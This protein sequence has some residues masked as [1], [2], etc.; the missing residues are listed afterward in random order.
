MFLAY[1]RIAVISLE[2]VIYRKREKFPSENPE[3]GHD[4]QFTF[5]V[6][7][8]QHVIISRVRIFCQVLMKF[9]HI[10]DLS[11]NRSREVVPMTK[12][13]SVN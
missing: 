13:H 1:S 4:I 9:S 3:V 12:H 2:N 11:A 10:K 7:F 8:T 6:I 5:T